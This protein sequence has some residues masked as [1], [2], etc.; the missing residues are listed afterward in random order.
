MQLNYKI[1]GSGPPLVIL[2]GLFGTLDNWQTLARRWS[3]RYT[4][5]LVDQR[6]H[7]RSPHAEEMTYLHMAEDLTNFL[8]D[9]QVHEF[10]LLGHSMGGK[11]A[12]QTALSYP[13]R[14]SKLIVVDMAPR[15]YG[16]GHDDIFTALHALRPEDLTDRRHADEVLSAHL[17]DAGIRQFLLKNLVRDNETGFRWRMNLAVLHREYDNLVAAVGATDTGYEKPTLFLR[18]GRSNYV[19]DED[20]PAILALFPNARLATVAE[21]GHWVHAEAPDELSRLVNSFLGE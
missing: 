7:G 14:V 3:D 5:I 21:A 9:L 11:A 17:P 4:L 20:W 2:H 18:G 6:N 13:D 12:M 16:R 8:S 19:K 1:F 10:F 15:A